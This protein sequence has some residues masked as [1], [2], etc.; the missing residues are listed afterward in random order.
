V[1]GFSAQGTVDNLQFVFP[2]IAPAADRAK[3]RS[4]QKAAVVAT[5]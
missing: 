5:N 2:E 3:E 1:S 4:E